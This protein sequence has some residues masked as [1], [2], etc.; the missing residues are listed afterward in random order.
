[1]KREH[2]IE[3]SEVPLDE[4]EVCEHLKVC[5]AEALNQEHPFRC[6]KERSAAEIKAMLVRDRRKGRMK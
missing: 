3:A 6:R 1:M 4:C 5:R 2:P